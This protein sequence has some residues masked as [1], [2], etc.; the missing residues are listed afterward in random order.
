MPSI[1]LPTA[2]LGAG[3]LGVGGSIAS[4]LIGSN[5]A[6]SA[7]Q[8]QANAANL[9]TNTQLGIFNQTQQNL[10]PYN[11]MGQSALSQLANLFG[12]GSGGSGPTSA[13]AAGATSALQN[14]PGYQFGL[15]QGTKALDASAA[16]QGLLLSGSQLQ[17]ANT[18]GQNYALQNAWN[19]YVSQL[20]SLAG[21]GENAAASTGNI[22]ATTGS[23]VAN[24]QLAAGQAQASGIV[25]SANALT[26]GLTGGI[27]NGLQSGLLALALQQQ[28]GGGTG[29]GGYSPL[30]TTGGVSQNAVY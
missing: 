11:Q 5:A 6:Q 10:A 1:S 2:I 13:T 20:S 15:S 7:A 30:G 23:S 18:F 27:Q 8:T 14:Y 21:L 22:G 4:G 26:S 19:P 16:S 12:L 3:A 24:T 29:Q 17:A 28:S 25:G 9:A